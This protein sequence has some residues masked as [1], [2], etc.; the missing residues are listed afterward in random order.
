MRNEWE[1]LVGKYREKYLTVK[2]ELYGRMT[3]VPYVRVCVSVCECVCMCV[4]VSVCVC[5]CVCVCKIHIY[6]FLLKTLPYL[7]DCSWLRVKAT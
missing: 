6:K 7:V 2:E 5:E 3:N 4:C 1:K